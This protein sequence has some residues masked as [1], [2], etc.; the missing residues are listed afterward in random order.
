MKLLVISQYF[1]PE[2][3]RVSDV[4][5]KLAEMGHEVTILTGLPNYPAGDIFEGYDWESLNDNNIDCHDEKLHGSTAVIEY[6]KGVRVIRC[7]ISPRKSGK[8][9]LAKN[10]F[11][12][13]YNASKVALD[14]SKVTKN[15]S[16]FD[17]SSNYT[18]NSYNFDKILVFQYSPVTMAIPGIILNRKLKIPLILY[19]FDLWP[20]SIV[21]AGLPNRGLIYSAIMVLSKWIYKKADILLVSSQNFEKYF[22]NKLD[23][24]DNIHYLPIYAEDIFSSNANFKASSDTGSISKQSS[25]LKSNSDS[26]DINLVFAGNIGEMQSIDTIVK[27]AMEIHE[28]NISNHPLPKIHFH[29][30]GDGSAL[31]KNINLANDYGL[32]SITFHGRHPLEDMPKFYNMADAFLVTLKNDEF[33]SYTLPGKIQSYMAYGKPIIGSINGEAA[34]VINESKCGLCCNAEDYKELAKIILK[35][36]EE[37]EN[38]QKYGDCSSAYYKAN[39]SSES[40]FTNLIGYL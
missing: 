31:E 1:Y 9:K 16:S 8:I 10:Y 13:A 20:E 33:I 21:S 36:A 34:I 25:V 2:Q 12:F 37:K 18:N 11:S 23:I 22:N 6:I 40:F 32:K 26:N 35:F 14:I 15:D 29:I 30:V 39:F 19:C 27:A 38:R 28:L 3:F 5:F 24:F 4:C 17:K 7:K